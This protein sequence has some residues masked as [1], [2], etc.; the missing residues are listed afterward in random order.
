MS[1]VEVNEK[2]ANTEIATIMEE[3]RDEQ[4]VNT[5]LEEEVVK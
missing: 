2:D 3:Q 4:E 5:E 1:D